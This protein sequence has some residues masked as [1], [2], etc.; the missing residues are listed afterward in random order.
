MNR[1][2]QFIL[3]GL[4]LL[5]T[6]HSASAQDPFV[7]LS[8][9]L[10]TTSSSFTQDFNSLPSTGNL[11][12]RVSGASLVGTSANGIYTNQLLLQTSTGAPNVVGVIPLSGQYSFGAAGSTNRALGSNSNLT[13]AVLNVT[14]IRYGILIRNTTGLPL[15][16]L[17]VNYTGKQWYRDGDGQAQS[18]VFDYVRVGN[19]SNVPNALLLLL[20]GDAV[21]LGGN[22]FDP[23]SSLISP[24]PTIQEVVP[25]WTEIWQLTRQTLRVLSRLRLHY[26]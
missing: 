19:T 15:Q 14:P 22:S 16:S 21:T 24:A 4:L 6:M 3:I 2:Y 23:V 13:N 17:Q 18:L 9:P 12:L 7:S 25:S 11:T 5:L 26:R 8:V 10:G 20:A 1:L